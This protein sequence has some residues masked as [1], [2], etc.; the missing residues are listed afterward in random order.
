MKSQTNRVFARGTP[1]VSLVGA[2][3]RLDA[4]VEARLT[5]IMAW[6]RRIHSFFARVHKRA[7]SNRMKRVAFAF[8]GCAFHLHYLVFLR[9]EFI[10]LRR[11][12]LLEFHHGTLCLDN[13]RVEFGLRS[14]KLVEITRLNERGRNIAQRGRPAYRWRSMR[15]PSKVSQS[16]CETSRLQK[17]VLIELDF[18]RGLFD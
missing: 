12:S 2:H 18:L 8:C 3:H 11:K 6:L 5:E 14:G 4:S 7:R 1:I 10:S 9:L 13:P 16:K 15:Y 17:I